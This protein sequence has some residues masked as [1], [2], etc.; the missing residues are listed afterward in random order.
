MNN[1]RVGVVGAG[2]MGNYHL[3]L[4][5]NTNITNATAAGFCDSNEKIV[6][7]LS[8]QYRIPGYVDPQRLCK[9]VD[10]VI[11]A[12][13]TNMHYSLAKSFLNSGKHVLIEKPIAET[14]EQ[15]QELVDI[16]GKNGLI[17]HVGHVE[18]FNGAVQQLHKIVTSPFLI[19]AR[20]MG[21][22][23]G[24]SMH[25]G[26]TLDLMIHDIDIVLKLVDAD[27]KE[28][29]AYGKCLTNPPFEDISSVS[30]LF[31]N[32]SIANII[33]SRATQNKIRMLTVHQ[34]D[35]YLTLDYTDQ[36][37]RIHRQAS[38]VSMTT[39]DAI[40]YSQESLVERLFVHKENPLKME[41]QH[42][43]DCILGKCESLVNNESDVRTL[44]VTNEIMRKIHQHM[45]Q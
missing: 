40:R 30:L 39:K 6:A 3:N 4:L 5:V 38:S 13:P 12:A 44:Q 33:A 32:G 22:S 27:V 31:E 18:R 42:Y 41:Q 28:I 19:E 14:S 11:I 35:L 25:I 9:D 29:E 24:R 21:P 20:R 15:A 43:I 34:D 16:A 26:V 7:D 2:H 36:D 23:T 8:E 45:K 10:A 37:I 17:L 1:I